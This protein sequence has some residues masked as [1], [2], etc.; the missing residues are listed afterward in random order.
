M[1]RRAIVP[2]VELVVWLKV[3]HDL[4]DIRFKEHD[5]LCKIISNRSFF[6]ESFFPPGVPL[7]QM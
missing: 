2:F 7:F 6:G 5:V 1:G 3:N 4:L